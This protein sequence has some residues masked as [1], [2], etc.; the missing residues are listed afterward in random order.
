MPEWIV[1]I[2]SL[3]TP[4]SLLAFNDFLNT[5]LGRW[6]TVIFLLAGAHWVF[7]QV[8]DDYIP[9]KKAKLYAIILMLPL[10][11]MRGFSYPYRYF[12]DLG[13]LLSVPEKLSTMVIIN[14]SIMFTIFGLATYLIFEK[15]VFPN[16]LEIVKFIAMI[17]TVGIYRPKKIKSK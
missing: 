14:D 15:Y 3:F 8:L 7:H 11:L 16:K 10:S 9:K 5:K 13:N 6:L 2:F 17:A 1:W 4:E 12:D